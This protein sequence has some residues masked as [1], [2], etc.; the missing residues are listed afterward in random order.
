MVWYVMVWYGMVWYGMVWY[1]MVW[2]GMVWYGMV[3]YGMVWYG[4]V[5]YGMVWYGVL[6]LLLLRRSARAGGKHCQIIF[7]FLSRSQTIHLLLAMGLILL[8]LGA[9]GSRAAIPS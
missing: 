7:T 1:G 4:M 9:G 8:V 5:W 3:W 2:Y 6:L